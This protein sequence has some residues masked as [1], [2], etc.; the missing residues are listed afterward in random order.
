MATAQQ[1]DEEPETRPFC[2][3]CTHH[4]DDEPCRCP[5][6]GADAL[7]PGTACG[8]AECQR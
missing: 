7:A 8:R 1:P 6:C 4:H 2:A 3:A 5:E